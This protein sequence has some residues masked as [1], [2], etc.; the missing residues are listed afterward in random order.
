[1]QEKLLA[2]NK[3]IGELTLKLAE[4]KEGLTKGDCYIK[5]IKNLTPDLVKSLISRLK[6]KAQITLI[7]CEVEGKNTLYISSNSKEKSAVE[8]GK[9]ISQKLGGK[10]GG[11]NEFANFGGIIGSFTEEDIAKML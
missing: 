4:V 10:G 3:E 9:I 6:N 7:M 5:C 2:K 1:L 8:L 11:S